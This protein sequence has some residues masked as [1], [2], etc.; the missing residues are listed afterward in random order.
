MRST[1]I[2]SLRKSI[3]L[4]AIG[5]AMAYTPMSHA[6]E[7]VLSSKDKDV[8]AP[9]YSEVLLD[10]AVV[11]E[12]SGSSMMAQVYNSELKYSAFLLNRF[13]AVTPEILAE[14][15]NSQACDLDAA[16]SCVLVNNQ[17][18]MAIGAKKNSDGSI[19]VKQGY[20]K[21]RP[22]GSES[23]SKITDTLVRV[24]KGKAV[25]YSRLTEMPPRLERHNALVTSATD[26]R[27]GVSI[28][29]K[30]ELTA[31]MPASRRSAGY[32][33]L[34][35]VYFT[36][37]T[38]KQRV[39]VSTKGIN[40]GFSRDF[41]LN[42]ASSPIEV[43]RDGLQDLIGTYNVVREGGNVVAKKDALAISLR[44]GGKKAGAGIRLSES[45]TLK[46]EASNR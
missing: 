45:A 33:D 27:T 37:E 24:T 41:V 43:N 34:V 20:F 12:N 39:K 18:S 31:T 44:L 42:F 17:V 22:D 8:D 29:G 5:F 10:A 38:A 11:D 15:V 1:N 4:S 36:G 3:L 14:I 13:I 25:L 28:Q 32:G 16:G 23:L 6:L 46:I 19:T 2:F 21:A 26:S 9:S 30:C 7:V 35:C 40:F